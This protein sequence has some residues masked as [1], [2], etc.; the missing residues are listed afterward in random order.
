MNKKIFCIGWSKTGTTSLEHAL[1]KLGYKGPASVGLEVLDL[2]LKKEYEDIFKIIEN[3]DYFID[4]PWYYKDF[5]KI[6]S[7]KYNDN[8]LFIL[9]KRDSLS[10]IKSNNKWWNANDYRKNHVVLKEIYGNQDEWLKNYENHN[11]EVEN[12]FKNNNNFITFD[13]ESG[14]SWNKLCDFLKI[15]NTFGEKEFLWK[16]KQ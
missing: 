14:D 16:N 12:F 10:W 6:L 11:A 5:Y 3:Y 2:L 7:K 13:A 9:T 4:Y 15:E 8:A 1:I